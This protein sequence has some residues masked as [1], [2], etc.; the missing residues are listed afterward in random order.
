MREVVFLQQ[1]VARWQAAETLLK[2]ANEASADTLAQVYLELT[3][4]LAYAQT[5]YPKSKT[6]DYLNALAAQIHQLIYKNKPEEKRRILSFW[7]EEVPGLLYQHR[8]KLL[9]AF[10]V[11][12]FGI[13][14]GAVSAN[15]DPS[16]VRLILGDAYVDMTLD[17]IERGNPMGVYGKQNQLDMFWM[18]AVNNMRVALLAFGLG[19][20]CSVGTVFILLSNGIML[21]AFQTFLA[22]KNLFLQASL[23]IWLHGTI[24]IWVIVVAGGAGFVMGNA[25]LFPETYT[26]LASFMRGAK[27]GLKIVLGTMPFFVLAALIESF[28]TR[29]TFMPTVVSLTIIGTSLALIIWYFIW[30]PSQVGQRL[31]TERSAQ[32]F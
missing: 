12:V 15:L 26:R 32:R 27:E 4:D 14:V 31:A 7:S 28:L 11:F 9:T 19:A 25:I 5:Y 13:G 21:G 29:Y 20:L 10:C 3:D 2:T 24:E 30:Y 18:I 6:T 22:Q 1:N 17:N 16:F 23:S 8:Q